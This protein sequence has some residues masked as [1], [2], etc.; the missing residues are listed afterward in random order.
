MCLVTLYGCR[1]IYGCASYYIR[2]WQY[3]DMRSQYTD[4]RNDYIRT[5]YIIS[6]RTWKTSVRICDKSVYGQVRIL[7]LPLWWS[8]CLPAS[9]T[10]C[11]IAYFL[12][13]MLLLFVLFVLGFDYAFFF[14][15][16]SCFVL[17]TFLLLT[18]LS[19][20]CCMYVC[21][22]VCMSFCRSVSVYSLLCR[23]PFSP[24]LLFLC[25]RYIVCLGFLRGLTC[26]LRSCLSALLPYV[27][28]PVRRLYL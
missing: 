13:F 5:L 10:P 7:F 22:Y 21:M 11:L 1:T 14:V 27:S 9:L 28:L 26:C 23:Y 16:T 20:I 12:F 8:P 17:L 3:T 4:V 6:V 25:C 15:F 19:T 2:I 18:S 24:V